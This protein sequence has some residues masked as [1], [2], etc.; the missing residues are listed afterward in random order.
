M[1]IKTPAV[2]GLFY[3]ASASALRD[4]LHR[5]LHK[6]DP[7][8]ASRPRALIAPH[9]GYQYS[10]PIAG[11]AYS[12][13]GK[14]VDQIQRVVVLAPSHRVPFSGIATSSAGLFQ[15]PLGEVPVDRTAVAQL[16]GLP[17]VLQLDEAFAQEHALEVQLPFLQAV[18]DDFKLVPLIVGEA[19][20][21]DVSRVLEALWDEDTLIVVSSDLS[22][23]HRYDDAKRMDADATRAIETLSPADLQHDHACGRL[24]VGGLLMLA[25]QRGW[26]AVTLD[27]RNSGDTAG[28]RDQVVG[29][30]AY[31]FI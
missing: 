11:S 13:L 28:P 16:T 2:A 20:R 23:Y 18:L 26:K 22:H 3:P 14:W 19:D 5:Y 9:A 27:L 17:G 8:V 10:G 6:P 1:H 29:Y 12:T 30:G 21:G 25:K 31:A 15:T 7:A 24:G 4:A